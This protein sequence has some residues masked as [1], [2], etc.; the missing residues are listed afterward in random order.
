[1]S[2]RTV[3]EFV[4]YIIFSLFI[5]TVPFDGNP[6]EFAT[7]IVASTTATAAPVVD[8]AVSKSEAEVRIM[9]VALSLIAPFRVVME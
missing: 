8:A 6:E 9:E 5:L 1:M 4:L 7:V 2:P 3:P